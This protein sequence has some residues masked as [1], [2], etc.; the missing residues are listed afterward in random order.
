M[1]FTRAKVMFLDCG[2]PQEQEAKEYTS[3]SIYHTVW[4]KHLLFA[5][6]VIFGAEAN[7]QEMY[8]ALFPGPIW[9]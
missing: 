1:S 9:L 4:E 5:T 7:S 2:S 3:Y 6:V 8:F